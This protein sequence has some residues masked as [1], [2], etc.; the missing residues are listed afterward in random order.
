MLKPSTEVRCDFWPLN[1]FYYF[2]FFIQVYSTCYVAFFTALVLMFYI[3]SSGYAF[4]ICN[5]ENVS[6]LIYA[7][8]SILVYEFMDDLSAFMWYV[9]TK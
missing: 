8:C 9:D 3:N 7:I 6:C 1:Q 2:C 5:I 4:K